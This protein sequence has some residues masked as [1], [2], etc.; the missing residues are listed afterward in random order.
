MKLADFGAFVKSDRANLCTN[1]TLN[2]KTYIITAY[3]VYCF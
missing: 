2:G 1:W 3:K